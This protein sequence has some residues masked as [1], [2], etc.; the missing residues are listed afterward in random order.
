MRLIIISLTLLICPWAQGQNFEDFFESKTLRLD[1]TFSG[2]RQEQTI[3]LDELNYYPNWAGRK[4]NLKSTLLK[5]NGTITVAD[6]TSGELIYKTSFS[7]LFQEWVDT[8]EAQHLSKS[9]ENT[10]LVPFPKRKV[11]ISVS[12]SN[13]HH[14]RTAHFKHT[15]DPQDILIRPK[16]V[17][18]I[19]PYRIIHNATIKNPINVAILAEGYTAQ[20]LNIFYKDAKAAVDAIFMHEPFKSYAASF[21]FVAVGS[22]SKDTGVSIPH[23]NKWRNTAFSSTFDT[24]YSERYL[25]TL[26]VKAIHDALAG[27]PYEHIIILANTEQYGGGGIYN[28]YTLTAAHDKNFKPVVVHEFGHSFGGL[29]DE[30]FYDN[31]TMSGIY[32]LD[33]EPWEPNIT[34][35]V[36]F[37]S[38]WANTVPIN[39]PIP[40]TENI[41]DRFPI[42]IY[43][44]AG[45]SSKGIYRS[46]FN[47]RMRTNE[48]P[49]FCKACQ[50]ALED[51]ILFYTQ[52]VK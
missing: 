31:D 51:L 1:Y 28:S 14:K 44:G 18:L 35:L 13:L 5:G 11:D 20:E 10:F 3:S 49:H 42:G 2:N 12:L 38:K 15:V 26:K 24:F 21:N 16:G 37:D 19:T 40:T 41:K 23:Q 33:I 52:K 22:I 45:Y 36:N 27:I 50:R 8:D 4:A 34:T 39:T 6:H 47:C 48:Y 7:S 29:A 25:T 9:F 30:Y 46:E 17:E 43:E 32:P